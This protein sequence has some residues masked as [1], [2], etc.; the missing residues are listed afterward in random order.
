MRAL[1]V[2]DVLR[3]FIYEDG[4]LPVEGAA[5]L[6]PRQ[7]EE[8][9]KFRGRGDPVIIHSRLPRRGRQGVRN[10]AQALR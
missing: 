3:D 7:N 10:L 4:A 1:L 6:V 5:K 9:K 8:I 2:I